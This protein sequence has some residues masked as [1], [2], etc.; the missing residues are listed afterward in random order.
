MQISYRAVL[1]LNDQKVAYAQI[2]KRLGTTEKTVSRIAN[3]A[4]AADL[5]NS[6]WEQYTDKQ[7][8]AMLNPRASSRQ[9]YYQVDWKTVHED[10]TRRSTSSSARNHMTLQYAYEEY[11]KEAYNHHEAPMGRSKFYEDYELWW[12]KNDCSSNIKWPAGRRMEIDFAGDIL[13]YRDEENPEKKVTAVLFVCTLSHSRYTYVE[14]I[15]SQEKQYFMHG[16]IHACKYFGATAHLWV[17]DC[18][19]A[20]VIKGSKTDWAILN[21]TMRDLSTIYH[22]ETVP[23]NPYTPKGING[24]GAVEASVNHSYQRI[25]NKIRNITFYSLDDLNEALWSAL[26]EF[27]SRPFTDNPEW[28]RKKAYFEKERP[29]MLP[30]PSE[31][32]E[33]RQTTTAKVRK[34]YVY[35]SLDSYYYSIPHGLKEEQVII[36]LGMH[37]VLITS[38]TNEL[39]ATHQRGTD[40]WDHYVTIPEHLESYLRTYTEESPSSFIYLAEEKAGYSTRLVIENI[41]KTTQYPETVYKIVRSVLGLGKRFGYANL[42]KACTKAL[43][44]YGSS[45]E[46]RISYSKL[47]PIVLDFQKQ[48][49]EE[50]L[51]SFVFT[52]GTEKVDMDAF[53]V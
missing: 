30:L 48:A 21:N 53:E 41:F 15:P 22:V 44:R 43:K 29:F 3:K 11:C 46:A 49:Q 45:P 47:K 28:T 19:K 39:I 38:M 8:K 18:T 42:E 25:Y 32:F 23:C 12:K 4:L 33:L 16:I 7:L 6:K 17:P 35:C 31:D 50:R 37:D 10:L 5:V 2:A 9:E 51:R 26:E 1:R 40:L 36:K 14:A 24:K 20:A 27:N 52:P 34:N 13:Y